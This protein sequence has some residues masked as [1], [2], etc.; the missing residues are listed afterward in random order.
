[1]INMPPRHGKS[2]LASRRFPAYVLG[3][4]RELSIISASYNL[5]K[6]QEFGGEVLDIV[7]S[8]EYQTLF[9]GVTL[10]EDTRAKG[11]WRT[12][13][14]GYY[15]AAG[16]DSAITGRGTVGPIALIDD[17]FKDRAE[18]DSEIVRESVKRWYSS[19][20]LSRFPRAIIAV[21]TRW[22]E[23][24]LSG[25]LLSM[26]EHGGD[27][28][29]V[30]KLPAIDEEGHALWPEFYPLSVLERIRSSSMPRDWNA[31]Y[32]Q[33]PLPEEGLFLEVAKV[34]REKPPPVSDLRVF[35]ASDYATS[36]G[37]GDY[38]VHIIGGLDKDDT[39]HILDLWRR[40]TTTDVWIEQMAAMV[41]SWKPLRWGEEGGVIIKAVGPQIER[42]M[43]SESGCYVARQQ[44]PAIK[45][46]P[47]RAR[48]LQARIAQSKLAISPDAY[49]ADDLLS[50]MARFPAAKHDDQ[51]DALAL[52]TIVAAEL[53][54]PE[55]KKDLSSLYGD[56]SGG[57]GSFFGT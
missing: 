21:Q 23:D 22:N 29:D 54:P 43:A 8:A 10:K 40:Q 3:K 56:S 28:W 12:N 55:E 37:S 19:T 45:D 46:K 20:I 41:K 33:N 15:I 1:M 52:L 30:L 27:K 53:G 4:L 57:G 9:P 44:Y 14:G 47:T 25:W 39:L 32:Q 5:A 18:A 6:A 13:S 36:D 42:R 7:R 51:V 31:L 11:F 24:D 50:E 34:K 16:V 26:E 2:E 35:A 38:S 49:W 17:P 48:P